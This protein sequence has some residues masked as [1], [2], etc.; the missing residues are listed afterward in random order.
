MADQN[1]IYCPNCKQKTS[2]TKRSDYQWP[3]DSQ[4]HYEIAE[5]NS[6]DFFVLVRRRSGSIQKIYPDPLPKSIHKKTPEFLKKDLE[7]ANLCFAVGSYR[8]AG[9]MARRALQLCYIEKGA[10]DKKL[11][12]QIDWLLNQQIITKELKEWAHEVRLTGNDAAQPPKDIT[13]DEVVTRED[14]DDILTLLE[15]FVDVLYIAPALADE[16]RQRRNNNQNPK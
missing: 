11:Q 12:D 9:V 3:K 16:R 7:E 10:P 4:T 15:K 2:I 8:A 14:A 1:S 6:C 13:K 5:C